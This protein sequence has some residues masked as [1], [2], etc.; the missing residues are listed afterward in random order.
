MRLVA[1]ARHGTSRDV[2]TRASLARWRAEGGDSVRAVALL[3]PLLGD[4][5]NV[6]GPDHTLTLTTRGDLAKWR[7]ESG[8]PAGAVVDLQSLLVDMLSVLGRG[9]PH[10]LAHSRVHGEMQGRGWRSGGG[11][12][13]AGAVGGRD[14][15][16]H[17]AGSSAH[18]D[19]ETRSGAVAW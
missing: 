18:A 13:A 6:F 14:G 15:H 16:G 12:R 2:A 10:T 19:R 4:L 8:G 11:G 7:A 1:D 17:W 9:H 5:R 3:E